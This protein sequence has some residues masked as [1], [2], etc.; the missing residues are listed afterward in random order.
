ML[1]ALR[2]IVDAELPI[3]IRIGVH[4]G[5]VFAGDIGPFY[6]RTYTVMGDAVNLS[7]RLM[8][9]AEP[10]QIYATA[11][12]LDRSNTLF[13]NDR[14][15][16]VRGQG[17]GA[18]RFRRGRSDGPWARG[19]GNVALERLP[20]IGRDAEL[21]VHPRGA[22]ERALRR[23]APDRDRRAKP[24]S[25]RPACCEALRD[26]ATGLR[27]AARRLR[28]LYRVHAVC[29]LA[30][31]PARVHGFR[32]RRS[33]RGHHGAPARRS[34]DPGARPRA[35]AAADRHRV[36]RRDRAD[37]RG[38]DAGRSEPPRR[39]CTKPSAGSSRS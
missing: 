27:A 9:K 36:R 37:S 19:R 15:R 1:L 31:A 3:P 30:R 28:G 38:R 32:A 21:A 6:R 29:G 18:S 22:R 10:G 35:V 14:A 39:S 11:D 26:D 24:A 8:A 23:G 17:Q 25:A 12:V 4:R 5:S 16:A 2:K 7:A 34:G 33:R 20:L 13:E